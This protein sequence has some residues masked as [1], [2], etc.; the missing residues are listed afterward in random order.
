MRTCVIEY[1]YWLTDWLYKLYTPLKLRF[2]PGKEG[3]SIKQI[4]NKFFYA[5]LGLGS[6]DKTVN[7]W[8][9]CLCKV[10]T[11]RGGGCWISTKRNN[12]SVFC[13]CLLLLWRLLLHFISL[14]CNFSYSFFFFQLLLFNAGDLFSG[15]L[16]NH[17]WGKVRQEKPNKGWVKG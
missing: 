7:R 5:I 3:S 9:P 10:Y 16:Q 12:W 8:Y 14:Y 1:H 13:Y 17:R 15:R 11:V 6:K 2:Y 4:C